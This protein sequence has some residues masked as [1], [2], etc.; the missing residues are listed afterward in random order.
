MSVETTPITAN[1]DHVTLINVFTVKPEDQDR[2]VK[3]L[4]DATDGVMS[5]IPGFISA[6]IHKSID[7]VRV[8]NYAQ[9][10]S[11]EDF[12]A[13]LN[14]PDAQEHMAPIGELATYDAHIYSVASV[15]H[16]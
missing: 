1:P 10:R 9:W 3:L 12:Q 5:R 11:V 2:L 14:N 7:G 4:V 6:N 13:M 16:I 15:C 8:A